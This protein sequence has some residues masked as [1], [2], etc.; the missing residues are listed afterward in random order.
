M[1]RQFVSLLRSEQDT[2]KP[3]IG[4]CEVWEKLIGQDAKLGTLQDSFDQS[5]G[6]VPPSR[7]FPIRG[8]IRWVLKNPKVIAPGA[9]VVLETLTG[10]IHQY[11]P[12]GTKNAKDQKYK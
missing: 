4:D 11:P 1:N 7:K 5:R 8:L 9:S 6:G 2:D 12:F 10:A 3:V